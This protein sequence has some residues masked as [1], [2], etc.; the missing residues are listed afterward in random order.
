[1]KKTYPLIITIFIS[2]VLLGFFLWYIHCNYQTE[3]WRNSWNSDP[4]GSVRNI[5]YSSA[6]IAGIPFLI[7]GHF[8]RRSDLEQKRKDAMFQSESKMLDISISQMSDSISDLK[9][10][11]AKAEL[12]NNGSKD[13]LE[14]SSKAIQ[15]YM[16]SLRRNESPHIDIQSFQDILII[17]TTFNSNLIM[18]AKS[19]SKKIESLLRIAESFSN[20]ELRTMLSTSL[21]SS[22]S[23][24][25]LNLTMVLSMIGN[26]EIKPS[27]M[28]GAAATINP[29]KTIL[30]AILSL[31]NKQIVP[32]N[33]ALT[34]NQ[35]Y[36]L[37]EKAFKEMNN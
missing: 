32:A 30:L 21:Y 18:N 29:N 6:A 31:H 5:I 17:L 23:F 11:Y 2:S 27:Y 1:M 9:K 12:Y 10:I 8:L 16:D 13:S 26:S 20:E 35:N 15:G 34:L 28:K 33:V 7:L 4:S 25:E 36:L 24:D 37:T 14:L 3:L 22:L 19:Q